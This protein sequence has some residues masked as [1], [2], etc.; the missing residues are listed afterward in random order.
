MQQGGT[1]DPIGKKLEGFGVEKNK[2]QSRALIFKE[3]LRCN[4]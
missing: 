4:M 3:L 1:V 2:K